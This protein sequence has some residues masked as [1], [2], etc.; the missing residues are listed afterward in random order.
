[1]KPLKTGLALS[2]TAALFYTLY[3]LVE[4]TWPNQF[5][6]FMN[7]LFHGLD[8]RKLMTTEPYTRPSFLSA[9][10]ILAVWAFAAGAFFAWIHNVLFSAQGRHVMRHE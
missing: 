5:M 3:T 4:V 7:G 10:V 9:L 2:A 6:G 8:F 1:M